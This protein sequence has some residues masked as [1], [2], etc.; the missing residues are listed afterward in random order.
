MSTTSTEFIH[1]D[2]VRGMQLFVT[3]ASPCN[4]CLH[5]LLRTFLGLLQM[6]KIAQCS[7]RSWQHSNYSIPPS[8]VTLQ[9]EILG[10]FRHSSIG[11]GEQSVTGISSVP[12]NEVFRTPFEQ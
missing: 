8:F 3:Q 6:L 4:V 5:R 11:I 10:A 12:E 2:D 7:Q 1:T 9:S